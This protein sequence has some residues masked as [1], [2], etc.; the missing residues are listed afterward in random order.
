M[1]LVD[2]VREVVQEREEA[3]AF[4]RRVHDSFEN[5]PKDHPVIQEIGVFL[6][7]VKS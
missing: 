6:E 2:Q 7:R 4:L 1:N 3:I 5:W